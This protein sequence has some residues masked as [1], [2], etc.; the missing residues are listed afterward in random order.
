M[1]RSVEKPPNSQ[2]YELCTCFKEIPTHDSMFGAVC[3]QN[4]LPSHLYRSVSCVLLSGH[5]AS[6]FLLHLFQLLFCPTY[7]RGKTVP[8]FCSYV[9]IILQH[10]HISLVRL[11][12]ILGKNNPSIPLII[13]IMFLAKICASPCSV[14]RFKVES[15]MINCSKLEII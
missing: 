14:T 9:N 13:L 3:V 12:Y 15:L 8:E 10:T 1:T 6:L 7:K 4:P 11:L 2:Y 5:L